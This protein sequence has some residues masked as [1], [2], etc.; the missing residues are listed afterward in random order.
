MPHLR[1]GEKWARAGGLANRYPAFAPWTIRRPE[2]FGLSTMRTLGEW[3]K[4]TSAQKTPF[5]PYRGKDVG[6]LWES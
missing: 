3:K 6:H 5:P 2:P 4:F 1:S